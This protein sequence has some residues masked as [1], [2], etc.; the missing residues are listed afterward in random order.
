MG[1][2]SNPWWDTILNCT[3]MKQFRKHLSI[4]MNSVN[5]EGHRV[6]SI[7]NRKLFMFVSL[8]SY[9]FANLRHKA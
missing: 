6:T 1:L 4:A 3:E 5:P 2:H 9:T 7:G 8:I